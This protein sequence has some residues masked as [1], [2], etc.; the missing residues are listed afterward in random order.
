MFSLALQPALV[1]LVTSDGKK[2]VPSAQHAFGPQPGTSPRTTTI[3]IPALGFSL[4]GAL[5]L[6][7][8]PGARGHQ[9]IRGATIESG[10]GE[11]TLLQQTPPI[12]F[13]TK[14]LNDANAFTA[15]RDWELACA[16]LPERDTEEGTEYYDLRDIA[17]C[18]GPVTSDRLARHA[19]DLWPNYE[20]FYRLSFSEALRLI[21]RYL[22]VGR[23]RFERDD[24][25]LLVRNKLIGLAETLG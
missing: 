22:F 6:S 16:L 19:K 10:W 15:W 12:L 2:P 20:G 9:V 3:P 1:T 24:L 21:K 8:I 25:E 11:L 13:D 23:R 5:N 17:R 18:L 14:R 7:T 4:F